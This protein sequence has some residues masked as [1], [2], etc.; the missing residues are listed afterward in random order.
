MSNEE[1]KETEIRNAPQEDWFLQ[2]LVNMANKNQFGM[3]ITLNVGGFLV[4]GSLTG[5]KQYFDGFGIDF[6][7]A[8]S[9]KE[10]AEQIKGSFGQYGEIYNS[11]PEQNNP[12]AY[13]HLKDAKFF[14]TQGKPIPGNRGVWWRGRISEVQGFILGSLS[15]EDN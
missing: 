4:S 10:T 8:F 2:S 9:D 12:P 6:A 5:G 14:N 3:G 11:E 13:I 1:I 15:S 7:S